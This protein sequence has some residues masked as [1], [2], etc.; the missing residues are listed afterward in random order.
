[1][2]TD[3]LTQSTPEPCPAPTGRSRRRRGLLHRLR[4]HAETARTDSEA[5]ITLVEV[6]VSSLI[7]ALVAAA[8]SQSLIGDAN[9]SS[10]Q[11]F[12]SQAAEVAQEDQARLDGMSSAQLDGLNQTRTVTV[13]GTAYSVT[14]TAQYLNTSGSSSC[15]SS[16]QG[17]AAY[18]KIESSVTWATNRRPPVAIESLLTPAA[19][20]TMIAQVDNQTGAGLSGATV[21]AT[22]PDYASGTT[23]SGGCTVFPNL[24]SGSFNVSVTDSGYVD[25]NGNSSPPSLTSTVTATGDSTTSTSPVYMGEAGTINAT[26]STPSMSGGQEADALSWIGA[27][28]SISMSSYQD[29]TSS[30]DTTSIST[31][32]KL[33]PFYFASSSNYANNYTAWAGACQQEEPPTANLTQT[34]V[35]PGGVAS[36]AVSEP[37]MEVFVENSSSTRVIPTDIKLTFTSATGS[38]CTDKFAV[39]VNTTTGNTSATGATQYLGEPFA[40]TATS[41]STESASGYT[42]S[43]TVCADLKSGSNYYTASS[44]SVQNNSFSSPTSVTIKLP[45][46]TGSSSC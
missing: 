20:G 45:S 17:A 38:A 27:G 3:P 12:R 35:Q 40:S 1:M 39:P 13:D 46:S 10:D 14:S 34:T 32:A 4:R 30:S 15:G 19:G 23:G 5:G 22:G 36:P 25:P 28:S 18:Y 24:T 44:S 16:G 33:F 8:V 41:G 26:F 37:S 6:I 29:T 9:T 31:G 42:G 11:R 21:T 43:Y 2:I 7:V